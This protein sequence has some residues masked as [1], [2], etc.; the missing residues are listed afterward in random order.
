M[1]V[2]LFLFYVIMLAVIRMK[3]KKYLSVVICIAILAVSLSA[4]FSAFANDVDWRYDETNKTL[5]VFG[6]GDMTDFSDEYSSPWSSCLNSVEKVVIEDGVSSVGDYAFSGASVLSAV[7]LGDSVCRVGKNA[8]SVCPKLLS[9]TLSENVTQIEDSSFA[10]NAAAKKE[11]FILNVSPASYALSFAVDNQIA[12]SCSSVTCGTYSG[13]IYPAGMTAYYPYTPKADGTFRF[14][15]KSRLDTLGA[16]YDSNFN[17]L[18]ANDDYDGSDFSFEQRLE[19]NKTYYVAVS[20]FSS[21]IAGSYQLFIEPV[22]YTVNLRIYAMGS[23]DGSPSS[24][25]LDGALLDGERTN[26]IAC[27]E[28]TQ[29]SKEITLTY[30]NYVTKTFTISPDSEPVLSVMVCDLN[31]DG[32]VNGI[33]YAMMKKTKSPFISL[34]Q[35]LAGYRY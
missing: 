26:G 35:N 1:C 5:Y 10:Y 18:N 8:F 30:G 17:E 24:I 27:I 4:V 20:L 13:S 23:P 7:T 28:L 11:K 12:F 22:S 2:E 16:I 32:Y 25:L 21:Y 15:S 29:P 31:G 6:S 34:F 14:S 33:D 3:H 19:K 9:L